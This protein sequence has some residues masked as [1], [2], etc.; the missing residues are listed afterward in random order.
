MMENTKIEELKDILMNENQE[1]RELAQ[2][3]QY[4]EE[5]LTELAN[6]TYPSDEEQLEEHDLK[7][8]KLAVKDEM[9]E[10][11]NNYQSAH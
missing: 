7:K 3:H 5:R 10:I 9:Y 4:F 2:Q 6:L 11:M 8:K 1:F